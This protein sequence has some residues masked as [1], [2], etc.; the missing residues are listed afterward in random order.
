MT[1]EIFFGGLFYIVSF[2]AGLGLGLAY[3]GGLWWTS[4]RVARTARPYL[5]L[6][7]SFVVRMAALLGG[8]WYVT[9]GRPLP[10]A[11]AVAGIAVGRRVLVGR[12]GPEEG[13]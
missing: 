7:V 4:Q 13:A 2:T 5:L 12:L 3:F 1:G 8:V 6:L 11:L 9:E 10:T